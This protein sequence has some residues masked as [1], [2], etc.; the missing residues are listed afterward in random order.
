MNLRTPLAPA[1][2]HSHS[3]VEGPELTLQ[4]LSAE[5]FI[6]W[7]L[8]HVASTADNSILGGSDGGASEARK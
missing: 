7:V 6:S 3:L 2:C 8:Q 5:W 1:G 4:L